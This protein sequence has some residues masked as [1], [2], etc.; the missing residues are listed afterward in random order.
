VILK[1]ALDNVVLIYSSVL[2]GGFK[3]MGRNKTKTTWVKYFDE[4]S[5]HYYLYNENTFESKWCDE[6]GVK[7]SESDAT[8][9]NGG[10]DGDTDAGEEVFRDGENE[11]NFLL[12]VSSS[13]SRSDS[14]SNTSGGSLTSRSSAKSSKLLSLT[15]RTK[16]KYAKFNK[17]LGEKVKGLMGRSSGSSSGSGSTP[18]GPAGASATVLCF[19]S[20]HILLFEGPFCAVECAV[21]GGIFVA[22]GL[23]VLLYW[24][25]WHCFPRILGKAHGVIV[26]LKWTR[27]CLREAALCG[28]AL[29]S[30][31][32][33]GLLWLYVYPELYRPPVTITA[34]GPVLPPAAPK[35]PL[36]RQPSSPVQAP[37]SPRSPSAGEGPAA[38]TAAG[39][40]DVSREVPNDLGSWHLRPLPTLLG[41]VDTRRFFSISYYGYGL[42]ADN[43]L[44]NATSRSN[45]D[46]N[47]NQDGWEGPML[48]IPAD[49]VDFVYDLLGDSSLD[50]INSLDDEEEFEVELEQ[51]QPSAGATSRGK[52]KRKAEGKGNG[53]A[54]ND[55]H[56]ASGSVQGPDCTP[57]E[58]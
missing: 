22:G 37:G 29:L 17:L 1:Q 25:A 15:A 21:R 38:A 24:I 42:L 41:P 47:E 54:E 11:S 10:Y 18:T 6:N 35:P 56:E 36:H 19:A 20:I 39:P 49:L 8:D 55:L 43:S 40:I 48:F 12:G 26:T 57:S 30:L 9:Q 50:L 13:S 46:V 53:K 31:L 45:D 51:L 3:E 7:L 52:G 4:E 27:L 32:V 44:I 2:V 58:G 33:P 23:L 34:S 16:N 28:A 14:R 5:Q